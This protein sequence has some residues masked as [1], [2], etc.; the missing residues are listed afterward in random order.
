MLKVDSGRGAVC[1]L[2]PALRGHRGGATFLC[3][4][5]RRHRLWMSIT[6][7]G[8]VA[9][10]ATERVEASDNATERVESSDKVI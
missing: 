5:S 3:R 1:T 9:P 2:P 8:R 7:E 10:N 6:S 4:A